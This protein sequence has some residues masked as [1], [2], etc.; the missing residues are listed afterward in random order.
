MKVDATPDQTPWRAT[1]GDPQLDSDLTPAVH[2]YMNALG[3]RDP[4]QFH[5]NGHDAGNHWT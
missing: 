3:R 2:V 5:R 1:I 4:F